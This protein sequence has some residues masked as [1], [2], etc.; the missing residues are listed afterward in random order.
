MSMHDPV[1]DMF[2]RIRNALAASKANVT[3]GSSKFKES[4]AELLQSEGYIKGY[5]VDG[6]KKKSLTI[7][8]K[9][10]NSEPVIQTIKQVSK[11]GL[12]VYS[13]MADLSDPMGPL[14]IM[15]VSTSQGLM[16][17]ANARRRNLGGKIIGTVA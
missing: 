13:S 1:S 10:H 9:Y 2:T 5:S 12:K 8:L 11:P 7:E 4:I 16:T 6:D 15:I 14:G 17:A 3:M